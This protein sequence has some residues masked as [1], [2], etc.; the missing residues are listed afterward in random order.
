MAQPQPIIHPPFQ[1]DISMPSHSSFN[2]ASYQRAFLSSPISWRPG[3]FGNGN[4]YLPGTSPG[5]LLGPLDPTDLHGAGKM[6]SSIESDRGSI[7]NAL[8]AMEREDELCR[9]YS[10][11]GLNLQD[12]HALV[13][14]FEEC[15]V[16]VV[17]PCSQPAP[18]QLY[19]NNYSV[20]PDAK[21]DSYL[22]Q[23][24]HMPR[25]SQHH[26]PPHSH[27][28]LQPYQ[29]HH[30]HS[31]HY[32]HLQQQQGPVDPDEMEL[33]LDSSPASSSASSPPLTPVTTPLVPY[34]AQRSFANASSFTP[35]SLSQPPSECPS[36]VSAFDTATVLPSR[37]STSISPFS[38]TQLDSFNAYST[39]PD[40]G[41]V[42]SPLQASQEVTCASDSQP[43]S[44]YSCV[45]PT[46]LYSPSSITPANTPSSS[47]VAS[48]VTAQAS[49]RPLSAQAS[50]SAC[51]SSSSP[52][53][54]STPRASTTLSRPASSLLLSKPFRCPKPNCNKS[55]KQA[56]GLKYHMTH[57]SCNFAPPKD[58]E[59]LQ[60]LLAEKG[61]VVNGND[62]SGV[63][64]TEGELREVEREA[65]RRLRP[66]ACGV[67]DCQRRYKNMNG[68]RYH[69]QHSGDHGAMGLQLLASGQHASLQHSKS[70][71]ATRQST[72]AHGSATP[73][74]ATSPTSPSPTKSAGSQTWHYP[75]G[76]GQSQY[77]PQ[78]YPA[79]SFSPH[80]Q[81]VPVQQSRF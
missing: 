54:T 10:C 37:A 31:Q 34:A 42:A 55:Y 6:S 13:E 44:P 41:S 20:P 39:Y 50:T 48:P 64:I 72:P 36:P 26:Q 5:Q 4:R 45:P 62:R 3:S 78:S 29:H 9:N 43:G 1:D 24:A 69:Y 19:P 66:F 12:L 47:R 65:E 53:P 33:D 75:Q 61:V 77:S 15:H 32:Q 28:H 76:Y 79:P 7:M 8:S 81:Q 59:A 74:G 80:G 52:S 16:V 30:Q 2:P 21:F 40:Y 23:S 25:P 27:L 70:A 56:N 17:D 49:Y 57:G 67:G 22:P 38:T 73:A 51:A 68:L 46:L 11:C 35:I 58:L 71:A 60:A 63:Q 18:G 14:H